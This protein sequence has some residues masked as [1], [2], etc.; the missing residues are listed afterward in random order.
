MK[1][2]PLNHRDVFTHLT[3]SVERIPKM[4]I[5]PLMIL[6]WCNFPSDRAHQSSLFALQALCSISRRTA[7]IPACLFLK[8]AFPF[9]MAKRSCRSAPWLRMRTPFQGEVPSGNLWPKIQM[10]KNSFV[11]TVFCMHRCIAVLGNLIPVRSRHYW[12]VEVDETTEFRIGV[13]YEDTERNSYLGANNTS[14]C[15]RHILTPTRYQ[16]TTSPKYNAG[17]DFIHCA[18]DCFYVPHPILKTLKTQKC[19]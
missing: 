3:G 8:M 16:C 13:A 14:W 15:M 5:L 9:F 10:L 2:C 1:D 12:E 4:H 17:K 18:S 6:L 7:L 19:R 11:I